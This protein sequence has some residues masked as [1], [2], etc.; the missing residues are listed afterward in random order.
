MAKVQC[1]MPLYII[2]IPLTQWASVICSVTI[3]SS[4][5]SLCLKNLIL[6]SLTFISKANGY[7]LWV[8]TIML[9]WC[10]HHF[11]SISYHKII[12]FNCHTIPS[13]KW[14]MNP[15]V[16]LPVTSQN[17]HSL[18]IF[19]R[20]LSNNPLQHLKLW[21]IVKLSVLCKDLPSMI[22]VLPFAA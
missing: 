17:H 6:V 9:P 8:Q 19:A 15:I 4:V 16:D 3:V 13:I 10:N 12:N 11:G 21:V 2:Q 20:N 14:I 7:L 1:I 18:W 22:F 5:H